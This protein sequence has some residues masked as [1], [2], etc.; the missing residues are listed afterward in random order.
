M[1][2][3]A[4]PL[5]GVRRG[6]Q[7][8]LA[9]AGSCAEHTQRG[10]CWTRWQQLQGSRRTGSCQQWPCQMALSGLV[11]AGKLLG[12]QPCLE[13]ARCAN[14]SSLQP[15]KFLTAPRYPPQLT[16]NLSSFSLSL[17]KKSLHSLSPKSPHS[18]AC[19]FAPFFLGFVFYFFFLLISS[20]FWGWFGVF[21]LF[22]WVFF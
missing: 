4:L 9:G 10:S 18:L 5:L 1:K 6:R 22:G 16:P 20:P 7:A 14:P 13:L 12:P 17:F 19:A 2:G 15:S 21:W 3:C 8:N 11:C